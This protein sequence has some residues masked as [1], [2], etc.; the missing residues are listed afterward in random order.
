[1]DKL[2]NK[3][4]KFTGLIFKALIKAYV[5][6]FIVKF[7][8]QF[9]AIPINIFLP[10][11]IMAGLISGYNLY[12]L[13]VILALEIIST[14]LEESKYKISYK[15]M[16]RK[17]KL[18]TT[19]IEREY[20]GRSK[21]LDQKLDSVLKINK[22]YKRYILE[23][24]NP[25]EILY[26]KSETLLTQINESFNAD[27]ENCIKYIEIIE[28]H[29]KRAEA[30]Q[31]SVKLLNNCYNEMDRKSQK[32]IGLVQNFQIDRKKVQ[33]DNE[34]LNKDLEKLMD[35]INRI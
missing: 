31:E 22:L 3:F 17:K 4:M 34:Y 14:F 23:K 15:N 28:V 25:S 27:I 19:G 30:S 29:G 1:M 26:S 18:S 16:K 10:D 6:F 13:K 35:L 8:L 24:L 9:L 12:A 32:L 2:F 33:E 5:Y 21:K 7:A 20:Y 11:K